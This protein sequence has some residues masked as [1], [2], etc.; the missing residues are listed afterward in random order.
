MTRGNR[1]DVTNSDHP[2][3]C[4]AGT[5]DDG[6]VAQPDGVLGLVHGCAPSASLDVRPVT[7]DKR[8]P[9]QL[10]LDPRKLFSNVRS[11]GCSDALSLRRATHALSAAPGVLS[12]GVS[13]GVCPPSRHPSHRKI[14]RQKSN[15][16][17]SAAPTDRRLG[18]VRS[19]SC[20]RRFSSTGDAP[21]RA[22]PEKGRQP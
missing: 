13:N 4:Q 3:G 19:Q 17:I 9:G 6:G 8:C 22:T 10:P 7:T 21:T 11:L 18:G 2:Q 16:R 1:I 20:V 15:Q 5:K 14:P 12:S